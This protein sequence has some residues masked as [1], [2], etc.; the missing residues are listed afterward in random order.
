VQ[1][2]VSPLALA[3]VVAA[4]SNAANPSPDAPAP[5]AVP[6]VDAEVADAGPDARVTLRVLVLN[7]VAAAG[8]PE[9]WFEVINA[10]S[11]PLELAD[12]VF[13][14][15]ADDLDGAAGFPAVTLPAGGRFVQD[16]SSALNGF[17]LGGDEELWIYRASDQ[18]LSDGVDWAEGASPVDGSYARIPDGTGEFHTVAAH[19]RDA[20]NQ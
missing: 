13:V 15:L 19:T 3:L 7:E 1:R 2:L 10:T 5:D 4:C 14:D 11:G 9:D 16:V 12:F 8:A 20:P 6:P 17:G 18:L